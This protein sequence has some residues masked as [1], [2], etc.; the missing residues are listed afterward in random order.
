MAGK[1]RSVSAQDKHEAVMSARPRY[2]AAELGL[3]PSYVSF[4]L[5]FLFKKQNKWL[6]LKI[7]FQAK[8]LGSVALSEIQFGHL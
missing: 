2:W 8:D 3:E 5:V 6:Q 1:D 4:L 7:R